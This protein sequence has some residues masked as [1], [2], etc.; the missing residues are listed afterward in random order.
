MFLH[1]K[2]TPK[3]PSAQM[4][5]NGVTTD[6]FDGRPA[7]IHRPD[8]LSQTLQLLLLHQ[9][10]SGSFRRVQKRSSFKAKPTKQTYLQLFS[11]SVKRNHSLQL[12]V[13]REV[14]H[15]MSNINKHLKEV[16]GKEPE[17]DG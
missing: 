14:P 10:L 11:H 1:L 7:L 17:K 15:V 13:G 3:G 9:S 6:D 5:Q 12:L 8:A 4:V 16:C 2:D